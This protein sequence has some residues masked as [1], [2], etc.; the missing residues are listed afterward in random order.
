MAYTD[1]ANIPLHMPVPGS[2]EPAQIALLNENCVTLSTH[3]H[4]TGKALAIGRMRSGLAANRPAAGSAGN[5]YFSTDTG[6]FNVDTGTAWVQF[7]TSGGQATVTGWTLIDPIVR[8]TINWGPEGSGTIDATLT[9]SAAGVWDFAGT[10]AKAW[11]SFRSSGSVGAARVGQP[12]GG[13]ITDGLWLASNADYN[14]T[15][16]NRDTIASPAAHINLGAVPDT[17]TDII[18]NLLSVRAG[19]N[20]I[21]WVSRLV[22]NNSGNVGVGVSPL[23]WAATHKAI[24]FGQVGALYCPSA[25]SGVGLSENTYYDGA[26]KSIINAPASFAYLINGTFSVYTA[27]AVAAATAQTYSQRMLLDIAG[28]LGVGVTPGAWAPSFKAVQVAGGAA[29]WGNASSAGMWLTSNTIYNGTNRVAYQGGVAGAEV[30]LG[31]SPALTVVT[32]PAVGA[33]AAQTG[34]TRLT[35]GT[36]GTLTLTPDA[37]GGFVLGASQIVITGGAGSNGQISSAGSVTMAANAGYWHPTTDNNLHLGLSS[38]RL[39]DVWAINGTIQT[40]H[41]SMKDGFAPLDPA[42][43]ADAVLGT[44][45]CEFDY[46]TDGPARHQRGYVLGSDDHRTSPL[47]GLADRQTANASSDLAVVACA[48]QAALRRLAALE[49]QSG[50]SGP[51]PAS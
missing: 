33:G 31:S 45:W 29:L 32:Y 25:A 49:G 44:D 37:G 24:Q 12:T 38:N 50:P 10:G 2:K 6:V 8:D 36:T 21:T 1:T 40:S 43:C 18:F 46:R 41:V 23:A 5:V 39:I 30:T 26:S 15:S 47:F 17:D 51:Q 4:T 27:P 16:W 11:A 7:L 9:R 14:G 34:T 20:P 35:V 28:N 19:A 22:V 48:L 13:S 42:A 3:D